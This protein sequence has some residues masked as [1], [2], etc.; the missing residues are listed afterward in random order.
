M[1]LVVVVRSLYIFVGAVL[2][3][4]L[5]VVVFPVLS[6]VLWVRGLCTVL[7]Y[8]Q[9]VSRKKT[10][11]ERRQVDLGEE[12]Q[13]SIAREHAILRNR[14]YWTV[15]SSENEFNVDA[16]LKTTTGMTMEDLRQNMADLKSARRRRA[17]GASLDAVL[18][19]FPAEDK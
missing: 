16:L 8:T 13:W 5:G 2:A 1:S 15:N 17:L 4:V 10:P 14:W 12:E 9:Q 6:V 11:W 3:A 19:R 18:S 7:H